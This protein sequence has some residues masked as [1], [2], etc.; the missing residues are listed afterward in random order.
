[1]PKLGVN[2]DH[3]ASIRQ[4]RGGIEPELIACACECED[5]GADSIVVHL[6]EDQRHIKETDVYLLKKV[7]RTRLNL[8]MSCNKKVVSVA[9]LVKPHQATLVPERRKEVTTEG[10]LD[11]IG[12]AKKI[13]GVVMK[14][15]EAGVTVSLFIDPV[16]KQIE[17]ASK[18]V[19]MIELHTGRFAN[20]SPAQ[21][22]R[23]LDEIVEAVRFAKG[24]DLTV[25]AGH[26]L[27]YDNVEQVARIDGIE[28]L[29]IGYSI[30]CQSVFTGIGAA[31]KRMKALIT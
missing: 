5:A 20:A 3:A 19:E 6:R 1:M 21:W 2:I 15:K 23:S 18:M 22:Q 10:G 4:L 13:Q 9:C 28:E 31:V 24:L 11:V 7:I 25:N 14:L 29:N 27:D 8:E 26:G 16:K 30:V 17:A 12:N